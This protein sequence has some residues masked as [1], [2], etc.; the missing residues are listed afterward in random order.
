M[1]K[2]S[3]RE[4]CE[5]VDVLCKGWE[6]KYNNH[7]LESAAYKLGVKKST[8]KMQELA[9]NIFSKTTNNALRVEMELSDTVGMYIFTITLRLKN[10]RECQ[11][12]SRPWVGIPTRQVTKDQ[13]THTLFRDIQR[14]LGRALTSD[15]IEDLSELSDITRDLMLVRLAMEQNKFFA[16]TQTELT[17]RVEEYLKFDIEHRAYSTWGLSVRSAMLD[18]AAAWNAET[19]WTPG[20]KVAVI[21]T[22]IFDCSVKTLRDLSE[23]GSATWLN[24]TDGS[25]ILKNGPY[26]YRLGTW[27]VNNDRYRKIASALE[28]PEVKGIQF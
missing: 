23:E 6:A 10:G 16:A 11:I 8:E 12:F 18:A 9:C 28:F 19:S 4:A 27:F 17:K 26:V 25:C 24:F 3:Y 13:F 15:S 7:K 20:M 2:M 5:E 14:V 21:H 22:D 1:I